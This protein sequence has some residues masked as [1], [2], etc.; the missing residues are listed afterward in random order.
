MSEFGRI[1]YR[2][3]QHEKVEKC[4]HAAIGLWTLCNAKC[5]RHHTSGFVKDD[6]VAGFEDE[7]D[8]L[9]AARLWHPEDGGYRYNNWI[10]WN[11]DEQ[12]RTTAARLVQEI[13]PPEHPSLVRQQLAAKVAGLLEEGTE[14]VVLASA[15]KLWLAKPN[16]GVSLLPHLVSDA[17]R[18]RGEGDVTQLLRDC[19][20]SG[21]V[22]PLRR[23]GYWF[24]EP[25]DIPDDVKTAQMSAY[26]LKAKRAWLTQLKKELQ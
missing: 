14:T 21:D 12:P 11:G 7:A 22:T 6:W 9:C 19:Y 26:M 20:K 24:P 5:R 1:H 13:I 4:S 15:L 23:H 18:S 17:V 3:D 2:F 8:E 16:A 10:K 25:D